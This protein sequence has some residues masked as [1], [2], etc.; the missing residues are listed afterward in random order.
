MKKTC[1]ILLILM[2]MWSAGSALAAT[3]TVKAS[4]GDYTNLRDALVN[5]NT[6]TTGWGADAADDTLIV[7]GLVPHAA[8]TNLTAPFNPPAGIGKLTIQG[9]NNAIIRVDLATAT[10]AVTGLFTQRGTLAVQDVTFMPNPTNTQTNGSLLG[11]GNNDGAVGLDLTLRRCVFTVPLNATTPRTNWGT[12]PVPVNDASQG[13]CRVC[14]DINVGTGAHATTPQPFHLTAENCTFA[15]INHS[16]TAWK[17]LIYTG[18]DNRTA[19]GST[20]TFQNCLFVG[21]KNYAINNVNNKTTF[22]INECAFVNNSAGTGVPDILF[23][24]TANLTTGYPALTLNDTIFFNSPIPVRYQYQTT[25]SALVCTRCTFFS[26]LTAADAG[27][28]WVSDN[29]KLSPTLTDCIYA[30]SKATKVIHLAAGA[31]LVSP[32]IQAGQA[33][34]GG[35]YAPTGTDPCTAEFAA[36]YNNAGPVSANPNFAS[37]VWDSRF[38]GIVGWDRTANNLLDVNGQGFYQ[39]GTTYTTRTVGP[40]AG[41]VLSGGADAGFVPA[42]LSTFQID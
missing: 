42:E 26:N 32:V 17:G 1:L 38:D 5:Y 10:G 16:A 40:N 29:A 27:Q 39:K 11:I 20:A 30:G 3:K 36:L 6:A 22:T 18:A 4:G 41:N 19:A 34:D 7:D 35:A 21:S 25:A 14:I 33:F 13:G 12:D 31:S 15:L 8:A 24:D 9:Q 28:I 2:I 23:G 37:T